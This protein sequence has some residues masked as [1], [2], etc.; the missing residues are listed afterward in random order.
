MTESGWVALA[1]QLVGNP[2]DWSMS[3]NWDHVY[4]P[5][6]AEAIKAGFPL[7]NGTDD[8]NVGH[9]EAGR[10]VWFGWMDEEHPA[11]DYAEVAKCF[12]WAAP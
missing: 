6:R 7:A 3:W 9:V 1:G 2:S 4:H 5:S 11:E 10:L 8:F 12:G